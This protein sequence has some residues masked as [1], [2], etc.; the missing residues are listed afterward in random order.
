[1]AQPDDFK[2]IREIVTAGGH[3]HMVGKLDQA[4]YQRWLPYTDPELEGLVNES[5]VRHRNHPANL[6]ITHNFCSDHSAQRDH[7]RALPVSVNPPSRPRWSEPGS[8]LP[9]LALRTERLAHVMQAL[10]IA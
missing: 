6:S 2:L 7:P 9:A 8:W 3:K 10:K 4:K 5:A 1:M